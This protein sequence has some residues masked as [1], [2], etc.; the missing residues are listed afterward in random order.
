[1]AQGKFD[2]WANRV[3]SLLDH[4]KI[5]YR[6]IYLNVP[7]LRP[8]LCVGREASTTRPLYS[9]PGAYH[10]RFLELSPEILQSYKGLLTYSSD[11]Q[12]KEQ[13]DKMHKLGIEEM[14]MAV[15]VQEMRL[16]RN[17]EYQRYVCKPSKLRNSWTM[18]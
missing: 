7:H 6:E 18:S 10:K 8:E 17:P 4:G 5:S 14:E 9:H 16:Y 15:I 11:A 12:K 13:Q 2:D 3:Y 1:M